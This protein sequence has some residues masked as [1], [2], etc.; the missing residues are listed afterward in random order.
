[1]SIALALGV[2]YEEIMRRCGYVPAV[3]APGGWNKLRS[4]DGLAE[5]E[6]RQL[7][8]YLAFIRYSKRMQNGVL[9]KKEGFS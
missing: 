2:D 3:G 7:L 4:I 9:R 6:E 5:D 1:M 8:E